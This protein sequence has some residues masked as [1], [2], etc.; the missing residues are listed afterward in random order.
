MVPVG[1][2]GETMRQVAPVGPVGLWWESETSGN[3]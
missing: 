2:G 1:L 3:S